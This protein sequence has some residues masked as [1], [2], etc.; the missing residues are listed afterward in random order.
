MSFQASTSKQRCIRCFCKSSNEENQLNADHPPPTPLFGHNLF[1]VRVLFSVVMG[2]QN[3]TYLGRRKKGR[4][5]Y[6]VG[7]GIYGTWI[8]YRII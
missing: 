8:V 2:P 4:I 6:M 7:L 3:V 1:Y 5:C